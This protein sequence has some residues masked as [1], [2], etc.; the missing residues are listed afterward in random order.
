MSEGDKINLHLLSDKWVLFAHL[1]HDTNWSLKSY[2]KLQT[3]KIVEDILNVYNVLPEALV[4]NCM[5]FLMKEGIGPN[6]EDKH[7]KNGGCFSFKIETEKIPRIW[8]EISFLLMGST[9]SEEEDLLHH[10]N[11]ITISPKKS[12]H[13]LKIWL[14]D[15]SYQN[16]NSIVDIEGINKKGCLFRRHNVKY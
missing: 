9:L 4:K 14:K 16:P 5:L 15:C 8:K 10:I 11:G 3:F 12:F 6:W 2:K 13:I 1:P 7:N